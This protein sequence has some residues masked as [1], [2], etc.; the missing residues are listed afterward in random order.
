MANFIIYKEPGKPGLQRLVYDPEQE[1]D[2]V[3][4]FLLDP[5]GLV[6]G[7][8]FLLISGVGSE[9]EAVRIADAYFG[10][11]REGLQELDQWVAEAQR[12]QQDLRQN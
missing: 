4:S 10:G 1:P 5:R 12:E 11:E 7:E 2:R 6:P 9:E 3:R 8:D